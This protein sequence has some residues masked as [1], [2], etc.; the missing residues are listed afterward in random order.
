MQ[1]NS[2]FIEKLPK[3]LHK[4]NFEN[5]EYIQNINLMDLQDIYHYSRRKCEEYFEMFKYTKSYNMIEILH[6]NTFK[7][8]LRILKFSNN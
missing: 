6:T 3:N 7:D 1:K 4:I 8:L 2:H 5:E